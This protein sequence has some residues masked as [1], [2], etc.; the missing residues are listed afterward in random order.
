MPSDQRH[1]EDD[2]WL[3]TNSTYTSVAEQFHH[4]LAGLVTRAIQPCDAA[5]TSSQL[6]LLLGHDRQYQTGYLSGVT[7]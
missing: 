4:E 7:V 2:P 3:P 1:R 5:E 6:K